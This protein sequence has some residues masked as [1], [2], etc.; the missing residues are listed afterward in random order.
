MQNLKNLPGG[1][2]DPRFRGGGRKG[3]LRGEKG[4]GGE[5]GRGGGRGRKG[6]VRGG[7]KF[8]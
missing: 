4:E 8:L 6:R 3:R 7:G 1:N 2:T 5:S